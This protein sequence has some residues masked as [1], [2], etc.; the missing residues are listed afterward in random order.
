VG[1]ILDIAVRGQDALLVL[2]AEECDV[3]LLAL[4]LVRVVLDG[5]KPSGNPLSSNAVLAV[6]AAKSCGGG[7]PVVCGESVPALATRRVWSVRPTPPGAE[8]AA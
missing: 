5:P 7:V 2:A 4:V 1:H 6:F 3:D 8:V